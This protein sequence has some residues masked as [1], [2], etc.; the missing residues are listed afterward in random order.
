MSNDRKTF[1]IWEKLHD[2]TARLDIYDAANSRSGLGVKQIRIVDPYSAID[3]VQI[4]A[5][6]AAQRRS[7]NRGVT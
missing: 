5:T 2:R 7:L 4:T 6:Q 3:K 1:V